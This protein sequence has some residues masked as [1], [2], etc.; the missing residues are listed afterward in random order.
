[1][2]TSAAAQKQSRRTTWP[3]IQ[4]LTTNMSKSS[5]KSPS[6]PATDDIDEDPFSHFLSPVL[7]EDDPFEG[8]E[9]NAGIDTPFDDEVEQKR[10]KFRVRLEEKWGNFLSSRRTPSPP[11][12]QQAP[13]RT[14]PSEDQLPE[15]IIDDLEGFGSP[16]SSPPTRLP[17]LTT[18]K[19]IIHEEDEEE[20]DGWE[21]D[22]R[23]SRTLR[24]KNNFHLDE[25]DRPVTAPSLRTSHRPKLQ[26]PRYKRFR[27]LSGR[28]H[29]FVAPSPHLWTVSEHDEILEQLRNEM[30]G[31]RSSR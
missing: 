15:L 23:R 2:S 8:L 10:T 18:L 4:T 12:S 13:P 5:S 16:S 25:M 3:N 24:R 30:R 20:A 21:G 14:P 26:R 17:S 29:S 9:Y 11:K 7:D 22:R 28:P 27:T 19:D 6:P 31:R 1:M